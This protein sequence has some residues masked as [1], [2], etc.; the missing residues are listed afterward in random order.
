MKKH[1]FLVICLI[2]LISQSMYADYL[3]YTVIDKTNKEA[4]VQGVNTNVEVGDKYDIVIPE[5]VEIDG[6]IYTVT[7]IPDK[8]F[9][10]SRFRNIILPNTITHIGSYVFYYSGLKNITIGSG[11]L[12][13]GERIFQGCKILESITFL[14]E[15]PP[16][17]SGCLTEYVDDPVTIKVDKKHI[18]DYAASYNIC[19]N[20]GSDNYAKPYRFNNIYSFTSD[21]PLQTLYD[22]QYEYLVCEETKECIISKRINSETPIHN[23]EIPDKATFYFGL[24][25]EEYDI[26]GI[27]PLVFSTPDTNADY[28]YEQNENFAGTIIIGNNI[29]HIGYGAFGGTCITDVILSEPVKVIDAYAFRYCRQLAKV[30]FNQNVIQIDRGAFE[31]TNITEFIAPVNLRNIGSYAFSGAPIG[32]IKFND[33][34]QYISKSAF[35]W[36]SSLKSIVLPDQL[37]EIKDKA[38]ANCKILSSVKF[39][40]NLTYIGAQAFTETE[41]KEIRIPSSV[42][43]IGNYAFRNCGLQKAYFEDG[44]NPIEIGEDAIGSDDLEYLYIGR[45]FSFESPSFKKLKN[46]DF[47]NLVS[48][49]P[50][51][52][53]KNCL[54]L[55]SVNF[56]S[57]LTEIGDEAFKYCSISDVIVPSKVH[58]IGSGAFAGNRLYS[59]TI[60][61][62]ISEIGEKAFEGNTNLSIINIT[63]PTPPKANVN[64]FT[65]YDS[66]LNTDSR[67]SANYKNA[68]LCWSMFKQHELINAD[69]IILDSDL[70]KYESHEHYQL[71]ASLTPENATLQTVLWESSNPNVA[72][73]NTSG[74]V[75]IVDN[76]KNMNNGTCNIRAYTLY[77]DGPI[78]EC[79]FTDLT[80]VSSIVL[81]MDKVEGEEGEQI[82]IAAT[83]LPEDATNKVI[84]WSSSDESVASVDES[85]LI[86]LLKK[87]TAVITA[88]ATD[89][90]GVSADCA[91]VVTEASEI[92]D[93]LADK[94]SYVKIF[95]LKGILIFEGKYSDARLTP[96]YY[97]VVCDGKSIKVKAQ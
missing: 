31:G 88:S 1:L 57:G 94:S 47:G 17:I 46:L 50:A 35:E 45:D 90:S 4:A 92:E 68:N 65:T 15:I 72:I 32:N 10:S 5:T 70:I 58:M 30:Q 27:G 69:S 81:N 96:D 93:I 38:F 77:S 78:A 48:E 37:R 19:Y 67:Y 73:V 28:M 21:R 86:S 41:L 51:S 24:A 63:A 55:T 25:S 43:S 56:G 97:I 91:I 64:T 71:Y 14:S 18:M 12:E 36:N 66:R 26:V 52:T 42:E 95:N 60:G 87:G 62:G 74:L 22:A 23:L 76:P 54:M 29:R 82:Q 33:K 20:N 85:G 8:G 16:I 79:I 7:T 9:Y 11:I 84:S 59:L 39:G 6:E 34:L 61:S 44:I 75:T 80:L 53:F 3:K 13:I 2:A 89:D 83:V 40:D 49:I